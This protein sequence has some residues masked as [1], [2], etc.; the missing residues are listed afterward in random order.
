MPRVE[1]STLVPGAV[2]DVFDFFLHPANLLTLAPPELRLEL[3]EGPER[4]APGARVTW[5]GRRWG[6]PYTVVVEV[7][8][9]QPGVLLAERQIQGPLRTWEHVRRFEPVTDG[10]RLTE[11]IDFEPPGGVLGLTV[12]A[13][14]IE[15]ELEAAFAHRALKLRERFGGSQ[16]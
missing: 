9:L 13:R 10:T 2:A 1:Q 7:T 15:Q 14:A 3:V 4:L 8:D 16:E 6:I 12:T 11:V 5:K